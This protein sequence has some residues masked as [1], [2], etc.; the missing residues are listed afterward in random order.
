VGTVTNLGEQRKIWFGELYKDQDFTAW[1][2][3]VQWLLTII[4]EEIVHGK[5]I[6]SSD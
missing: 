4:G 6:S 2:R 5:D 3:Y 1:D